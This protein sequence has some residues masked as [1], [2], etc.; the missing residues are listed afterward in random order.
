MQ[1]ILV[2]S[3]AM[4]NASL[5]Q[6][7]Q[8]TRSFDHFEMTS[9]WPLND[10][11]H[12]GHLSFGSFNIILAKFYNA[13]QNYKYIS[14]DIFISS[15]DFI[16]NWINLIITNLL[17]KFVSTTLKVL[18]TTYSNLLYFDYYYYSSSNK[19]ASSSRLD[20]YLTKSEFN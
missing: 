13:G 11:G 4:K 19:D 15:K 18:Q 14:C 6:W 8:M 7:W 9:E 17:W 10:L 5:L 16:K 20:I 3:A 1:H 12:W 2:M